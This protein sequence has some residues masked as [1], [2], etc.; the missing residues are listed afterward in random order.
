MIPFINEQLARFK[1]IQL[2]SLKDV[3]S[4]LRANALPTFAVLL[5]LAEGMA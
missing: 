2:K 3:S 1:N 4:R 5:L